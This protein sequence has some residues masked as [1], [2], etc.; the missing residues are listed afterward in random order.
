M[1]A[2]LEQQLDTYG[3]EALV[4]MHRFLAG[5]GKRYS[6]NEHQMFMRL[7]AVLVKEGQRESVVHL[8]AIRCPPPTSVEMARRMPFDWWVASQEERMKLAPL[9]FCDAYEQSTSPEAR[10]ELF[11]AICGLYPH[12]RTR[13]GGDMSD[14]EE[15]ESVGNFRAWYSKYKDRLRVDL[16]ACAHQQAPMVQRGFWMPTELPEDN[17]AT[18][19]KAS[20][21]ERE[22]YGRLLEETLRLEEEYSEGTEAARAELPFVDYAP[23]AEEF[24]A[25]LQAAVRFQLAEHGAEDLLRIARDSGPDQH[26][27]FTALLAVHVQSGQADKAA[28]LL[29]LWC[30]VEIG[31]GLP[32]CWWLAQHG[33]PLAFCEAYERSTIPAVKVDL[34]MAIDPIY[35]VAARREDLREL[36]FLL[37]EAGRQ[38]FVAAFQRWYVLNSPQLRV[39]ADVPRSAPYP[40]YAHYHWGPRFGTTA[41]QEAD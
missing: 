19:A 27:I 38:A 37:D 40:W 26:R 9:V 32:L 12:A 11:S 18:R 15:E 10:K 41:D 23:K 30:P 5:R 34:L 1:D 35:P 7:L 22:G 20:A 16:Y 6:A 13:P 2:A 14:E 8:L 3:P 29:A 25:S 4:G 39:I 21:E 24:E 17:Q 36:P 28:E 33:M 31:N